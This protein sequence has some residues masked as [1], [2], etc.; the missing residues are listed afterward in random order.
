MAEAINTK[1]AAIN[2]NCLTVALFDFPCCLRLLCTPRP[3]LHTSRFHAVTI[4]YDSDIKMLLGKARLLHRMDDRGFL[5]TV[6]TGGE[7]C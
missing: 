2:A 6:M 1:M 5:Q 3:I 4:K 7:A